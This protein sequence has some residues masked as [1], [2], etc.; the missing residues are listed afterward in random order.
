MMHSSEFLLFCIH[1]TND[2]ASSLP[3]GEIAPISEFPFVVALMNFENDS[4][5]LTCDVFW[6]ANQPE[7]STH[8]RA[9]PR[10]FK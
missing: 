8:S 10:G 3:G 4:D 9:L 2:G 5:D 6:V 7:C 1:Y